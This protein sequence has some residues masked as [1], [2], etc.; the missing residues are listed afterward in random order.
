[1]LWCILFAI[2]VW[3]SCCQA[4]ILYPRPSESRETISL[5]GIWKFAI[6]NKTDQQKGF[7]EMWFQMPLQHVSRAPAW[8]NLVRLIYKPPHC[9]LRIAQGCRSYR[10]ASTFQ[11]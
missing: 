2:L 8:T 4:G 10:H 6:S 1:M 3:P 9:I 7:Q 11:L 5:D